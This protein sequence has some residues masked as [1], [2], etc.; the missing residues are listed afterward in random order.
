MKNNRVVEISAPAAYPPR[1]EC[2][3]PAL[4]DHRKNMT[5]SLTNSDSHLYV[6]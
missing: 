1:G 5:S 6:Q 2:G 4:K 3:D